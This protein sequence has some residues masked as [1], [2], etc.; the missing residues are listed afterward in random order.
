MGQQYIKL[1]GAGSSADAAYLLSEGTV[2]FYLS[3]VDKYSIT[4]KNVIIGSTELILRHLLSVPTER[5]ETAVTDD[6]SKLKKIAAGR[7][8]PGLD[9]YSF[10]MNVSMVLA[11]QVLLTNNIIQKNL[12]AMEGDEKKVRE[13]ALEFFKIVHRLQEEFTKR[14][15]PWIRTLYQR[16]AE[17]LT[18][19][20]GE[21]YHK[22]SEPVRIAVE[23][24]RS[25][26]DREYPIGSIICEENTDGNEMFIL[27]SGT[28]DVIIKGNRVASI[29]EPGTV[30]G[31]MAL[32][33][34]ERRTAT[35]AARNRVIMTVVRK[36]D[37]KDMVERQPD[38]LSS[39]A[40]TL[41]KR[42]YYN[43]LKVGHINESLAGKDIDR[44]VSGVRQV[45]HS[46]HAFKELKLLKQA[47]EETVREKKADFLY[48]LADAL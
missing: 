14:K 20:K 12:A 2:F 40:Q 39:I 46:Q 38:F 16:H 26:R 42:H 6:A 17:T 23:T 11:R 33:L 34:G 36:E 13:F 10:A 1:Y 18:Y 8:L 3:T 43:V 21:A 37:L 45:A 9:T 31:E 28:L 15:L 29:D 27:K 30:I 22:S 19:K 35:L 5:V 44:E 25:D 32:L 24:G 47:V 48:D 4:G 7:F 41:A